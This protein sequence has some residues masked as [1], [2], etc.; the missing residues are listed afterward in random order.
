MGTKYPLYDISINIVRTVRTVHVIYHRLPVWCRYHAISRQHKR[1]TLYAVLGGSLEIGKHSPCLYRELYGINR[2][3][4]PVFNDPPPP[5]TVR[6][7]GM[8]YA[9][10]R[11]KKGK[12]KGE[13]RKRKTSL[14]RPFPS[15]ITRLPQL[16]HGLGGRH[17]QFILL[18]S[19]LKNTDTFRVS[20]HLTFC[21]EP[22]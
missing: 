8:L 3:S 13:K 18:C 17:H 16:R 9:G 21:Q 20:F 12:G 5:S 22:K 4:F 11:E 6:G 2:D 19:K 15:L 14:Y 10:K 7:E 1:S